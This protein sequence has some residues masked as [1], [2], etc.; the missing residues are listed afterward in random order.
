MSE[1]PEVAIDDDRETVGC[2]EACGAFNAPRTLE[3]YKVALEHWKSHEYLY[4]CSHGR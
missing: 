1:R 2:D 4:G 3:E